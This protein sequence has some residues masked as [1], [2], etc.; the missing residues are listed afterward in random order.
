MHV[1]F[2]AEPNNQTIVRSACEAAI[3]MEVSCGGD[4]EILQVECA[5][6]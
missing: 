3:A 6:P 1:L 5:D 4:I 2:G